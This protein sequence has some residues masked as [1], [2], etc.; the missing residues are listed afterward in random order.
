MNRLQRLKLYFRGP[1][2]PEL[3]L[4][5]AEHAWWE[6]IAAPIRSRTFVQ[7]LSAVFIGMLAGR[8]I[9]DIVGRATGTIDPGHTHIFSF[10]FTG[11][12]GLMG[13]LAG[14]HAL[15]TVKQKQMIR[16]RRLRA[17]MK[18]EQPDTHEPAA[19]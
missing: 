16:S 13:T 17:A 5:P 10:F 6:T 2:D 15:L 12:M 8:L 9:M 3:E 19:D 14:W 11:V 7:S 1:K 18:L 4:T